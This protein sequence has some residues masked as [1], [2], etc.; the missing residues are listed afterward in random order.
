[1]RARKPR[2]VAP[3]RLRRNARTEFPGGGTLAAASCRARCV[4]AEGCPVVS[5]HCSF[6][7]ALHIEQG[8]ERMCRNVRVSGF[9]PR[10]FDILRST[11]SQFFRPVC[12]CLPASGDRKELRRRTTSDAIR[13][14]P[15]KRAGLPG[16]LKWFQLV[17]VRRPPAA[18]PCL[19]LHSEIYR[20]RLFQ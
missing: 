14:F 10:V 6:A 15:E 8:T 20:S 5:V 3:F 17:P 9:T 4:L 13:L 11:N 12:E 2:P 19:E 18:S 16:S 1:M 7:F